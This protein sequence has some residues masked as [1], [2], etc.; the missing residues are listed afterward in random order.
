MMQLS[1]HLLYHFRYHY[2]LYGGTM[3]RI[4]RREMEISSPKC[5]LE[6]KQLTIDSCSPHIFNCMATNW[7]SIFTTD[8]G[9][10]RFSI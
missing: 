7:R 10:F 9:A 8:C 2:G 3:D 1:I 6:Q 4:H 5:I